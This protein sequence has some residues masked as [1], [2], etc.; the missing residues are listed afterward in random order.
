MMK[1]KRH[2]FA[3][4]LLFP[5]FTFA[6][7]YTIKGV[8]TDESGKP[9]PNTKIAVPGS[10]NSTVTD[11]AG[12]FT[13]KEVP[14]GVTNFEVTP[15]KESKVKVKIESPDSSVDTSKNIDLIN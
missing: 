12:E 7:S 4:Y 2:F 11:E 1:Y 10:S 5:L 3:I 9:V 15:E 8:I 14:A 13:L 6:Q